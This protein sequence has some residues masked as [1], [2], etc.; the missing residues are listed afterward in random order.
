MDNEARKKELGVY[1]LEDLLNDPKVRK[2]CDEYYRENSCATSGSLKTEVV[3]DAKSIPGDESEITYEAKPLGFNTTGNSCIT[4]NDLKRNPPPMPDNLVGDGVLVEQGTLVIGGAPEAG[5]TMLVMDLALSLIEGKPFLGHK[6]REPMNVLFIEQEGS[7]GEYA[8][9]WLKK[10]QKLSEAASSRLFLPE[11]VMGNIK[12]DTAKGLKCLRIMIKESAA[13]VAILDPWV[14]FHNQKENENEMQLVLDNLKLLIDEFSISF[15]F[16]HHPRKGGQ[17]AATDLL[18][19]LRG[20]SS[21]GAFVDCALFLKRKKNI[22]HDDYH[23]LKCAKMRHC[24][25][26]KD[27]SLFFNKDTF[28]FEVEGAYRRLKITGRQV[29]EYVASQGGSKLQSEVVAY[30]RD[31]Y[32]VSSRTVG[33]RIKEEVQEG[34]LEKTTKDRLKY[35]HVAGCARAA[36]KL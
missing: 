9:R 18:D 8:K 25:K 27:L 28:I 6:V 21:L 20:H 30:F 2:Q 29:T 3:T 4:L 26:P 1:N 23:I 19:E 11:R 31:K 10:T 13:K 17:N 34:H 35:I 24:T 14:A 32:D 16:P 7:K 15:V 36:V 22:G 33:D 5:K 12:L